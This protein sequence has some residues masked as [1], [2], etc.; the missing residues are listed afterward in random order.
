VSAQEPF[1]VTEAIASK[2]WW[3]CGGCCW[4]VAIHATSCRT[5]AAEM[6][7]ILEAPHMRK[8]AER[9]LRP[10][11]AKS[12]PAWFF[13]GAILVNPLLAHPPAQ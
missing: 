13:P 5:G 9:L 3:T 1:S 6:E 7:G 11:E 8:L 12:L 10:R 2:T 4:T